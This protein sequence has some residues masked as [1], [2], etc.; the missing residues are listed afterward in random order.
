MH[1]IATNALPAFGLDGG[2]L[3]AIQHLV[4]NSFAPSS[5]TTACPC[6]DPPIGQ[7]RR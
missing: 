1:Q 2:V 6:A 4:N 3:T 7:L 5:T